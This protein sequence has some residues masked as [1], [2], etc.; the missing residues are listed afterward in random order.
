M[1]VGDVFA[2]AAIEGPGSEPLRPGVVDQ[3]IRH[4]VPG[5]IGAA[6]ETR[7]GRLEVFSVDVGRVVCT[8]WWTCL[9]AE[10]AAGHRPCL[11]VVEMVIACAGGDGEH[12]RNDVEIH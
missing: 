2:G 8:R 3:R 6:L 4:E 10:E 9:V 12:L 1:G 11:F 5:Q 7:V